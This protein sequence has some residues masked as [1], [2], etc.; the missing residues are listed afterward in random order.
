[1][2]VT[3]DTLRAGVSRG[4]ASG[5]PLEAISGLV[6]LQ[7]VGASNRL[8]IEQ[9]KPILISPQR[10]NADAFQPQILLSPT[11]GIKQKARM[12]GFMT[13]KVDFDRADTVRR[14]KSVA[15]AAL[16]TLFALSVL[17]FWGEWSVDFS[18]YYYAGHFYMTDQVDMIYAG[19]PDIIGPEMPDEWVAAL[20]ADGYAHE[21]PYPFIYLPWVAA[22]MAPISKLVGPMMGM[23]ALL[24]LNAALLVVM[25][26]LAWRLIGRGRVTLAMWSTASCV[27][28][29][30]SATS[31]LALHLGQVQILVYAS[32]LLCFERLQAGKPVQA[33][34]AL[35]FAACLKI[36]PA[37]FAIIFIWNRSWMALASFILVST[38]FLTVCI[39]TIGWPLHLEYFQLMTA[40]NAQV[41][42]SNA[43]ISAEG[44]LYKL[45]VILRDANVV[46]DRKEHVATKPVWQ[47]IVIKLTFVMGLVTCWWVTRPHAFRDRIAFQLLIL[48]A[49]IPLM[50]PLG[51]LH[52]YLLICILLPV[53]LSGYRFA[54]LLALLAFSVGFNFNLY[55]QFVLFVYDQNTEWLY[56][57]Q[58]LLGVSVMGIVLV[59]AH[60]MA[61][62][63]PVRSGAT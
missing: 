12:N 10:P 33:G 37:A 56:L 54:G 17:P 50:L 35:A 16:A 11:D 41:F 40:L 13:D 24:V 47:A 46:F 32:V 6:Q 22:I 8:S 14:D 53:A 43:T 9:P 28:L 3:H 63:S 23:N 45:D 49:L 51:W 38:A 4:P 48:A 20:A 34:L 31:I 25:V 62:R 57:P 44:L 30:T 26:L 55:M 19:P 5:V 2:P 21:H 61:W 7:L 29:A 60:I 15:V 52:Y 1:M 27:I 39:A 42:L 58:M 18:A 36:T 59:W